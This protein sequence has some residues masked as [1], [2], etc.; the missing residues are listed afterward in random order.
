MTSK[1]NV[2]RCP[3]AL[4]MRVALVV[5]RSVHSRIGV[6]VLAPGSDCSLFDV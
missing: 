6:G 5:G 4:F 3:L 1:R 2:H